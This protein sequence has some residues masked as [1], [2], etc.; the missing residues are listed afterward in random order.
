MNKLY[1]VGARVITQERVLNHAA[2]SVEN[3]IITGV[4]ENPREASPDETTID[5]KGAYLSPGFVDVHVHGGGGYDFMCGN[6]DQVEACCK[7]HLSHGTTTMAA[8]VSTA[9]KSSFLKA[10]DA[11]NLASSRMKKGP[12]I[13]G[14]HLEGPYFAMNARG[15]QA[16][17][18]VR[19][20]D[21]AEYLEIAD[22]F[23]NILRW[24]AAPELP[25]ALEMGRE[26]TRRGIRM[27]IGHSD[28]LFDEAIRAY[29]CGYT[30]VTHLYSC[31]SLVKRINAYRYAGIVE[32]AF[33]LDD[34]WVE[35]IADGKHLPASLLKLIYKIKGPDR[36]MLITDATSAAGQEGITGEVFCQTC[37]SMIIVEDGVA[38]LPDRQ[39]F[40]G[41]VATT[42]RL[43]RTMITLADVPV[44][45][46][47]KMAS[48]TPAKHLGLFSKK[49]SIA[50]GKDA[51]LLVFDDNVQ[52]QAVY[53]GGEKVD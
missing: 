14:L 21:P 4:Y 40:A 41:S 48:A 53:V 25:G 18:F 29:E 33:L 27:S 37:D 50:V 11:I 26:M 10:M 8:T 42:D 38:K 52:I 6:A 32:A 13:A 20:P 3:G 36:I 5:L 46:A 30:C 17:R 2:V 24:A 44:F 9:E 34:M 43:V 16:A 15:A 7:L 31:T 47:V 19:N 45:Q 23:P 51:D 35:V 39:S 28:A 12:S 1:F 49:G 22:R